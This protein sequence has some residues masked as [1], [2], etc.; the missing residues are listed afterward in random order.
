MT[1][2]IVNTDSGVT[3][4]GGGTSAR[5]DVDEAL[6]IAPLLVA[7]DGGGDRA[8][9]LGLDPQAVIGDMDSLSPEA[10]TALGPK[11]HC[12]AEQDSTDFGKCL[13]MVRARFYLGVGFTGL[14]LDH[15]LAA[16]T[17]IA[18]HPDK[19][20]ILVGETDIVF[21]APPRLE[22]DLPLGERFSIMPFGPMKARSEGLRWPLDGLEFAPN[23]RIGTSNEV[24][25]P[26]RLSPD[27]PALVLIPK[28]HLQPALA[29]LLRSDAR[30]G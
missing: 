23:A 9:S 16:L 11:I 14:R 8:L 30:G 13:R 4:L 2:W 26:V 15:T 21:R 25:G 18:A 17:E 7:A 1:E 20:I 12:I 19:R 5:A 28:R 27:G 22:I 29:A 6:T 3:L 24:T 10:R